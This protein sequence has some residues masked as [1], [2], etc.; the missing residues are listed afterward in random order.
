[1]NTHLRHLIKQLKALGWT[2]EPTQTNG[3]P[4]F[5]HPEYGKVIV[6][7]TPADWED[8]CRYTMQRIHKVTRR[9][10]ATK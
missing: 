5:I 4:H 9:Y 2:Y 7:S 6:A 3:A 8:E 1:V 10:L